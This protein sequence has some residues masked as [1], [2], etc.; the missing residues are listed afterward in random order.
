[1]NHLYAKIRLLLCLILAVFFVSCATA[2]DKRGVYHK[3]QS[4]ENIQRI[5]RFYHVPVQELAEWNNITDENDIEPGLKIYIPQSKKETRLKNRR[6]SDKDDASSNASIKFDRTKFSWPVDGNLLSPFGIRNGR[7]H[8]GLDIKAPSG[9]PI[10]AA[11]KGEVVFSGKLK[12]YGNVVI[13]KHKDEFFTV[14]AH[15][16]LNKVSK[17]KKVDRGTVIGDVGATGRATGPHLHFEVREGQSAR[18]PLF[19]LPASRDTGVMIA[20]NGKGKVKEKI[21]KRQSSRLPGVDVDEKVEEKA[22]LTEGAPT[23]DKSDRKWSRRKEMMEKLKQKNK[24]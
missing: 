17:G 20:E 3:V 16:S 21:A 2:Y 4:G 14:Y 15:N 11:A 23:D 19:Y 1:M 12:G 9:T 8:D 18:N 24:R 6:R 13:V 10:K 5:A 7:R 22:E